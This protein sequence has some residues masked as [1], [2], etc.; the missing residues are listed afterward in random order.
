MSH[1]T[2]NK[3]C[4]ETSPFVWVAGA[5]CVVLG[6]VAMVSLCYLLKNQSAAFLSSKEGIALIATHSVVV[7]GGGAVG[8]VILVGKILQTI[9]GEN[10]RES[11]PNFANLD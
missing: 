6:A 3:S 2:N 7:L 4:C 1:I 11:P 8:G 10:K 9:L 5:G